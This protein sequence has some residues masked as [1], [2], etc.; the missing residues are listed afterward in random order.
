MRRLSIRMK[1]TLWFTA[2]LILVMLVTYFIILSANRQLLLKTIRDNLI[3]AVEDNVDEVEFYGNI[4]GVDL[5][6]ETDFFLPFGVGFLEIDDDFLEQVNEVCTALYD[7]D[8]MLLYGE[9]PIGEQIHRLRFVNAKV[10][11]LTVDDTLY[12]IFDRELRLEGTDGLWLRGVVSE[13]QG[14]MQMPDVM[15]LSLLSLPLL[16]FIS[17]V[18]GYLL[19][20]RLF[21]P[22]QKISESAAQIATGDDLKKRIAID[23]REDELH[24]LAERFNEMFERLEQ[25]FE[26]E[27]QFTA[28][29]SHE[30]RT[31]VAVILSQCEFSLEE[32]R[33]AEEYEQAIQTV[34]RQSRKMSKLINDM[35]DFTRLERNADSYPRGAV[36]MT[37]LVRSVCFDMA[38]IKENGI[39]LLYEAEEGVTLCGNRD[40]LARLLTN[41]IT[42]AYRYGRENGHIFVRLTSGENGIELSVKDD[43]IG[44]AKEEQDKI[45][46]RFYQADKSHSGRGTGLGLSMVYEIAQF[47]GGRISVESEPGRGSTFVFSAD[48]AAVT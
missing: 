20:K 17:A 6:N 10:Q 29:A 3:G 30:L 8:G 19:T 11:K 15:R 14:N 12:Y 16:V 18:G 33:S 2:A 38:L 48:R 44:I 27:R 43:G 26:A 36:D 37:E 31:P 5:R 45:F 46:R 23:G 4:D 39:T 22:I 35:L 40:L 25:A 32:P 41:L 9:N 13:H 21:W 42:N 47:H 34:R 24:Q 7:A 1:I 28:D